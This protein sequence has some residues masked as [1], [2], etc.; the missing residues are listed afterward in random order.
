MKAV[1]RHHARTD[2][3]LVML[4][5]SLAAVLGT[6]S[7]L[8]PVAG[9]AAVGIA[10]VFFL[11]TLGG[12]LPVLFLLVLAFLLTGYA[13]L[14]KGFAYLGVPPFYVG[15][16]VLALAVLTIIATLPR[17]RLS[18]LH[19]LLFAFMAWGA[20]RTI[21]SIS[22][23]GIVALRDGV[24]WGYGVFAVAVSAAATADRFPHIVAWYRRLIPLFLLWVPVAAVLFLGFRSSLPT[25]P[26]TTVPIVWFNSGDVSVHLAGAGAFL[27]LGLFA[28]RAAGPLLEGFLWLAW[29]VAV[30]IVGAITRG[31]LLAVLL[32]MGT[33]FL[34]HPSRR[35]LP[36]LVAAALFVSLLGLLNPELHLE[37]GR[38]LSLRQITEN[39]VSVIAGSETGDLEA[40]KDWRLRWW[41]KI[42]SYTFGGPYFW[43]GK[44]FG[45]NLADV[46]GF[47]LFPDHRLRAPHNTHLTVLARSG[48]PGFLLWLILQGAFASSLL[49]AF[50]R[51][52]R[53]GLYFWSQVTGWLLVYW[54]AAMVNTS[55]D[56]YLEGPQGGIWFWS[57]F[58]LG[59]AALTA[60]RDAEKAGGQRSVAQPAP[61]ALVTG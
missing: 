21:P 52:R 40:N 47:Q 23:E 22:R 29:F 31:G 32:G 56:P 3:L 8:S 13:F 61:A 33:A 37:R 27:L 38:T 1:L 54:I 41:K 20:V 58:G 50:L 51:A 34:L 5:L 53:K 24:V 44:G 60:Q 17:L 4:A 10:G 36:A 46:D 28:V 6:L 16:A 12:R 11:L 39:I 57:L 14:S 19:W 26:G 15:E 2:K 42:I 7:A 45:V 25:V 59:L 18:T 35:W 30:G 49:R 9:L 48:V 55:F 43:T